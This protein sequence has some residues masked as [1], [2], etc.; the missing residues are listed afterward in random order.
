VRAKLF[1]KTE[2]RPSVLTPIKLSADDSWVIDPFDSA[3]IKV[4]VSTEAK[5]DL[6]GS[7]ACDSGCKWGGPPLFI[8]ENVTGIARA[9]EALSIT[10]VARALDALSRNSAKDLASTSMHC[11]CYEGAV[12]ISNFVADEY[13]WH[14]ATSRMDVTSMISN[15][16]M[17]EPRSVSSSGMEEMAITLI[18]VGN[19]A[20]VNRAPF[21]FWVQIRLHWS[22]PEFYSMKG[23]VVVA[24]RVLPL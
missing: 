22:Q 17:D 24:P 15:D 10:A 3:K 9:L 7:D 14:L 20:R 16:V 13:S 8:P 5:L 4:R 6:A 2:N 19:S 18:L 11:D 23:R 1:F 21:Q 12:I